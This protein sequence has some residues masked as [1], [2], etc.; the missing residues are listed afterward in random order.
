[1]T[2]PCLM[3]ILRGPRRARASKDEVIFFNSDF[4][5]RCRAAA[6]KDAKA[7]RPL[8]PSPACGGGLGRGP[9]HRRPAGGGGRGGRGAAPPP[10]PRQIV[11]NAA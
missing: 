9:R 7:E 1:M 10:P 8:A 5:L 3:N 6:S 11:N 2:L 4:I